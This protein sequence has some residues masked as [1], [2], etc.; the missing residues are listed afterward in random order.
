MK[1]TIFILLV[2]TALS[3][4]KSRCRNEVA[5][6]NNTYSLRFTNGSANTYKIYI[7]NV[8]KFD[9]A[10]KKEYT[11]NCPAGYTKI[12]CT[13]KDGYILYPTEKTYEAN[14]QACGSYY[15]VFP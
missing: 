10:G 2:L 6:E 4:S 8:Y 11:A 1:K 5:K 3:C 15:L 7:N 14:V 9:I 12:T 13:Q